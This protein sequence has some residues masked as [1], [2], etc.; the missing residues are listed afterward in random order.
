MNG[1]EP[2]TIDVDGISLAV[3]GTRRGSHEKKVLK[4]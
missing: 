1:I 2:G 3:G 4:I